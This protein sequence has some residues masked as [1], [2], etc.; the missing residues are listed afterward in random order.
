MRK[1]SPDAPHPTLEQRAR[2]TEKFL[3]TDKVVGQEL[4]EIE[5][6]HGQPPST[7]S[8]LCLS[9]GG[10]RSATFNLGILQALAKNGHLKRFHYLS[11]V[12]GGGYIGSWLTSWIAR[13]GIDE[14]C[15]SLQHGRVP[16][17]ETIT[18]PADTEAAPIR[19]LR[20]YSRYLSPRVGLFSA[21]TWTLI[22]AYLRNLL[23]TW[24]VLVP[25]LA[26]MAGIPLAVN[27][28]VRTIGL[29]PNEHVWWL[30]FIIFVGA[31]LAVQTV[32]F[33][34]LYRPA[35]DDEPGQADA[36]AK[37]PGQSQFLLECILPF[38]LAGVALTTAWVW[39]TQMDEAKIDW[40]LAF[41]PSWLPSID[42][43]AGAAP[44]SAWA[45]WLP[46]VYLGLLIHVIGWLLSGS[47]SFQRVGRS[48]IDLGVVAATGAVCGFFLGVLAWK[49]SPWPGGPVNDQ[50]YTVLALPTFGGLLLL[51]GDL[52][53]GFTSTQQRRSGDAEREWASR[54]NAWGLIVCV[55]WLGF[56][57]LT[58][59]APF[60]LEQWVAHWAGWSSL[61]AMVTG[62]VAARL[63][64][65]AKTQSASANKSSGVIR[66]VAE[67]P[68]TIMLAVMTTAF[69]LLLIVAL[70]AAD[71]W[72]A[73][74]LA[75]TLD[76]ARYPV[77]ASTKLPVPPFDDALSAV[78]L[79]ILVAQAAVLLAASIGAGFLIDMN[80]FSLHGLYRMR[81][82][83][84]YLGASRKSRTPDPLIGF[85]AADNLRMRDLCG[86]T[87][88]ESRNP[89][90]CDAPTS[91]ATKAE[92]PLH[93]LNMA[94]NIVRDPDLA[95]QDR[96]AESFTVS[97][98]HA[99]SAGLGYRR[100]SPSIAQRELELE[101]ADPELVSHREAKRIRPKYYGGECGI[102]LGTA[103]AISG[104]A[105]SP[106][107][108]YHSSPTV[109]FL[110]TLF[111]AR[112]GWWLGNPGEDGEDVFNA[113]APR[114]SLVTLWKELF[115][116]T[117]AKEPFVYLSDGGHFDNLGLYEMVRRRC[118]FIVVCDASAD[119]NCNLAD[120]GTALR[121][122]SADF[123]VTV[124]FK[125]DEFK[126]RRRSPDGTRVDAD[127]WAVADICYAG[128]DAAENAA[129]GGT[130]DARN[131][132][133]VYIKPSFY[134]REPRD[135]Y[136]YALQ[137]PT[138]PHEST[139]DQFFGESQFESYRALGEYIG[140]QA[141]EQLEVIK[142]FG[143]VSIPPGENPVPT[144]VP[145]RVPD[146]VTERG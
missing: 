94:L 96:K 144:V 123:Q 26:A 105:A 62:A 90:R 140:M 28:V 49:A 13:D 146:S 108:G 19:H 35:E 142:K 83:R 86:I 10:I 139:A 110:M 58:L 7:L 131:G 115:G 133:L 89:V 22:A 119:A 134:G 11:T 127:Y 98:L 75:G 88:A 104:A 30:A 136:N 93:V 61:G 137:S 44:H 78:K 67:L 60:Y 117:T 121:R 141:C 143:G 64:N 12:S 120:L 27:G 14:V 3:S 81:L 6:R 24:I 42:N 43:T 59:I 84:A 15:A 16:Q 41:V 45:F 106:N 47:F 34:H 95:L 87:P 18:V 69:C 55:G 101:C 9:G 29:N 56:S 32:R 1:Q 39:V 129:K 74:T 77:Y 53:L 46:M 97:P 71:G 54:F 79:W 48:L 122:I 4:S 33:V 130:P 17:T 126:I 132:T 65:S 109:T 113:P 40:L 36:A 145:S 25:A 80:K 124:T 2:D 72:L 138:F 66:A 85:D 82:I 116:L 91:G 112:L 103:M 128:A 135:I 31:A 57:F 99:G 5:R 70:S 107:M 68:P 52:H 63:G 20:A 114:L 23:L 73:H 111:N 118:R 38:T 76:P 51:G 92:G 50:L 21:D 100:T 125:S 8:A 37:R 102:S